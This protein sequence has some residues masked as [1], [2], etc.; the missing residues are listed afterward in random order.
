M[1]EGVIEV[2][3]NYAK[4]YYPTVN[5]IKSGDVDSGEVTEV[6]YASDFTSED[7][8]SFERSE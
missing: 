3:S 2:G 6:I 8:Y 7:V 5:K 4:N 1:T